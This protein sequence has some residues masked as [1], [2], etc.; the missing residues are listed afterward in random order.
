ML[1]LWVST[2]R[3]GILA[4]QPIKTL[5]RPAG[6]IHCL[7]AHEDHCSN[8]RLIVPQLQVQ[9]LIAVLSVPGVSRRKLLEDSSLDPGPDLT[10]QERKQLEAAGWKPGTTVRSL[11]NF[12]GKPFCGMSV[13][14]PGLLA[15]VEA[16]GKLL[17]RQ[18]QCLYQT[19]FGVCFALYFSKAGT[20]QNYMDM[21]S[22]MPLIA[23]DRIFHQSA[24]IMTGHK[25]QSLPDYK[26]KI[27][28]VLSEGASGGR[29][30]KHL[31]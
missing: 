11:L 3:A 10:T 27:A 22:R 19:R 20:C 14:L 23:G 28:K 15:C 24:D 1:R 8:T 4:I 6:Y 16:K 21:S 29:V 30:T 26:E 13:C 5:Q 17:L 31:Q 25:Q 12:T 9:R 7:A 2:P 18:S